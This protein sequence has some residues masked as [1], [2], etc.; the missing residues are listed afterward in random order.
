[1]THSLCGCLNTLRVVQERRP[2][3]VNRGMDE[4]VE[5]RKEE[6]KLAAGV[7]GGEMEGRGIVV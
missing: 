4:E 5:G 2:G 1:M 3:S 6:R 7:E